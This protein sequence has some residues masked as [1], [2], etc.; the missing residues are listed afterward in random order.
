VNPSQSLL[1]AATGEISGGLPRRRLVREVDDVAGTALGPRAHALD[2]E[3]DDL[4]AAL[5]P[6][7]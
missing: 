7:V 4:E 5:E 6:G 1:V 3:A 2:L